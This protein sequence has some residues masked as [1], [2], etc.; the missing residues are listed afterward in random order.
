MSLISEKLYTIQEPF[1]AGYFEAEGKSNFQKVANATLRFRQ[2]CSLPAY[3]GQ[4]L[5][6]NGTAVMDN[7]AV[8]PQFSYVYQ[9]NATGLREKDPELAEYCLQNMPQ[10][11]ILN[12]NE[13]EAFFGRLYTHTNPNFERI[14]LEGLDSYAERISKTKDADFREGC[15][16]VMDSIRI[17]HS[18]C[19]AYLKSVNAKEELI[20]ALE[21]V[22]FSPADTIYEA[23]VGINFVYY[24]DLCDNLGSLDRELNRWHKGEDMVPV[25]RNLYQNVDANDGWSVKLGPKMY[26]IT[27]QL[28]TAC[29]GIRRPNIQLC[30][31]R[32]TPDEIWELS[33]QL[34]KSGS[35]N[36]AF[37]NYDLYMAGL[38]ERFP[39]VKDEDYEKI[40]FCDCTETMLSGISKAGS[41]DGG[42][43]TLLIFREYMFKNLVKAASFEDF[44]QGA[45]QDLLD[46]ADELY[47]K[48]NAGYQKKMESFP[49]PVRTVLVDDCIDCETDFN[50]GGARYNWSTVNFAG[51]I[52]VVEC[53]LAIRDIVFEKKELPAKTFLELLDKEDPA[54]FARLKKCPHYGVNDKRADS[55]AVDL[56]NALFAS[57]DG[58][59]M[60][61]GS[62][63]LT[64]SVQYITYISRALD[65]PATPDGRRYGEP[66]CDSLGAIMGNNTKSFTSML[67]SIASLDLQKALG[68]PVV[69]LRLSKQFPP[70]HIRAMVSAFFAQGGMQLQIT[71]VSK[72][73]LE[74][75]MVH[76]ENHKDLIVRTGGYCEYFVNLNP[77]QQKSIIARAEYGG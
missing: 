65:I 28:L 42:I 26:P 27:T 75:A 52:N 17:Y 51:H 20:A 57:A 29:K 61:Y 53:L 60:C 5:Y 24:I 12:S 6:P 34:L 67:S 77:A 7:Y 49:H 10:S 22:P 55:L 54:L 48:V 50:A 66:M 58:K 39:Q 23:L 72:E 14:L 19:L 13:Q 56:I 74:D 47:R 64:S 3:N 70:E 21:K 43:N 45:K 76:P 1:A 15:I 35:G 73:E 62:G 46:H 40:C 11:P 32:Q 30:V 71:C 68:T 38:K 8:F 44:Y 69:N 36:P 2:N 59:E 63:F 37:Y 16:A 41:V 25:I 18:R 31:D 9:I 33:A 4:W